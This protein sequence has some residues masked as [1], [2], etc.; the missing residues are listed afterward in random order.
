MPGQDQDTVPSFLIAMPQLQD[1]N[2][3]RSVVLLCSY[4]TEGAFGVI[5]NRPLNVNASEVVMLEPPLDPEAPLS[6][7]EGGPVD[8]RRPWLLRRDLPPTQGA[9]REHR[10]PAAALEEGSDRRPSRL[11]FDRTR[12]Y[13]VAGAPGQLDSE[14]SSSAWLLAPFDV[15]LMF[16]SPAEELW[17]RAI[18]SIGVEPG[19][20]SPAPGV[21]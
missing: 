1:P 7:W 15:D 20:I 10:R 14:L 8:Q 13:R 11:R 12:S 16:T 19:A 6:V 4:N 5:V 17:E 18:R 9:I 21:H 2:F 3:N